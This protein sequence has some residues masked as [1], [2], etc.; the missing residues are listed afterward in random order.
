MKKSLKLLVI[1]LVSIVAVGCATFNTVNEMPTAV[2]FK[3]KS[4]QPPLGKSL[5]YVVRPT[6]LGKPFGGNITANG[7][8]IGTTQGG[9][10]V[11][12][13]LA[14]GEYKFEVTGHDNDSEVVVNLEANKIYYIKESVFPGFWRGFTSLKLLDKDEGRKDLDN[15]TLGDK[16]GKNILP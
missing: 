14:P 5:V 9:M 6:L 13:V 2:D 7:E 15:C 10:Y 8:Y 16:L 4:L 11:Y 12:T 1:F 3:V